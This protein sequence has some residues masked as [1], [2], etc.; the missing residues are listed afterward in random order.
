MNL[1][2]DFKIWWAKP[3]KAADRIKAMMIGWM[4]GFW[5]GLITPFV[6]IEGAVPITTTGYSILA[7]I[8]I[9]GVLGLIIPK[10]IIAIFFPLAYIGIGPSN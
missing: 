9:L 10:W 5:I 1:V 3:T 2:N 8:L 6:I 7:G 4:A